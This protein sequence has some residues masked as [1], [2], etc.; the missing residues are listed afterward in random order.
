MARKAIPV[1]MLEA[2]AAEI[3]TVQGV[4]SARAWTK[5]PGKAAIYVELSKLN[6]GQNWHGGTGG[7]FVVRAAENKIALT[8]DGWAGARTRD[9]HAENE[10]M[11]KV[12]TAIEAVFSS[13]EEAAA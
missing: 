13:A 10:T 8:S 2:V 7:T 3:A 11:T 6:G 4:T 1:E 12:R 9:W 5:V